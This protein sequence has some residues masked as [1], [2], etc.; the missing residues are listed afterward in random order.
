[1]EFELDDNDAPIL[2]DPSQMMARD[3]EPI[4]RQYMSIHYSESFKNQTDDPF[5][6]YSGY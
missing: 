3:M 4:V 6:W 2:E 1:M 5:L